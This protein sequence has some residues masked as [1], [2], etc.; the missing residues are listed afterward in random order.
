MLILFTQYLSSA[1][2]HGWN[3][4]CIPV[5]ATGEHIC[6]FFA[7]SQRYTQ[8]ARCKLCSEKF[9]KVL[10]LQNKREFDKRARKNNYGLLYKNEFQNWRNKNNKTKK[11]GRISIG[12]DGK[13]ETRIIDGNDIIW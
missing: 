10:A 8:G 3:E 7:K 2:T 11:D 1:I 5:P 4:S 6:F 9:R 12:K 13:D